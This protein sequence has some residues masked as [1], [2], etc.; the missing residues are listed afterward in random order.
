MKSR[1]YWRLFILVG[2]KRREKREKKLMKSRKWSNRRKDIQMRRIRGEGDK[3]R[4][5][6]DVSTFS[7]KITGDIF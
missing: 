5:T 2:I 1:S 6:C 7:T 3:V 4:T